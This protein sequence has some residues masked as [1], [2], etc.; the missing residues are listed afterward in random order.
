[1]WG[2][3]SVPPR[4]LQKFSPRRDHNSNPCSTQL[5]QTIS[6]RYESITSRSMKKQQEYKWCSPWRHRL[7]Q[8][9]LQFRNVTRFTVQV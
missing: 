8:G 6:P 2:L 4:I 5:L 9:G 7:Y 3:F 1:M